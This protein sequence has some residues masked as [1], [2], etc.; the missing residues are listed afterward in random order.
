MSLFSS[1]IKSFYYI[2]FA[3]LNAPKYQQH[4]KTSIQTVGIPTCY[5]KCSD[6]SSKREDYSISFVFLSEQT[7]FINSP[8]CQHFCSRGSLPFSL[9]KPQAWKSSCQSYPN[10]P[11]QTGVSG[12]RHRH[13]RWQIIQHRA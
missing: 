5:S 12:V 3:P 8:C 4:S 11:K 7:L 2:I 10:R 9:P 1:N 6:L 13:R